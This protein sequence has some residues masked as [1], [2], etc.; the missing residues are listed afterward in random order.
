MNLS[1]KLCVSRYNIKCPKEQVL[2]AVLWDGAVWGSSIV[3][4]NAIKLLMTSCGKLVIFLCINARKHGSKAVKRV[5]QS[6][7]SE[8]IT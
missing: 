4:D 1:K 8:K 7:S 6:Q 2:P 5:T 3:Y